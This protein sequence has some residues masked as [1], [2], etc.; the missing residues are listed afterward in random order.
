MTT[1]L[2]TIDTPCVTRI[3]LDGFDVVVPLKVPLT[4]TAPELLTLPEPVIPPEIAPLIAMSVP[5]MVTSAF[6]SEA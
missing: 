2:D 3:E 4:E 6:I 5:V 1:L